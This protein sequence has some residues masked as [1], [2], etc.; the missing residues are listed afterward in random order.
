MVRLGRGQA[1]YTYCYENT[2]I[3]SSASKLSPIL[4]LQYAIKNAF[5]LSKWK[6]RI[7]IQGWMNGDCIIRVL[8]WYLI[9]VNLK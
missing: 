6:F 5:H 4:V 9:D 7:P 1:V 2:V 3:G 8:F